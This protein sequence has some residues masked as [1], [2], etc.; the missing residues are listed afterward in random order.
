MPEHIGNYQELQIRAAWYYYKAE[1]TQEEIAHRLGINRARVIKIL[2]QCRREGIVSFH[3]N[4]RFANCLELEKQLIDRYQLRAALIVPEIDPPMINKNLGAAGAQYIELNLGKEETLLGFGWGNT[5]SLTLKH[6][7]LWGH[8]EVSM[9]TL[10]GGI[11]AYLQNTYREETNPLFKFNSRFHIIPSPLL[12][13]SADTCRSIL[14]EP[15]VANIMQ[16]A[17]LANIA[18]VGIGPMSSNATFTQFGYI[19]PQELEILQ[20][21][22]GVGDILGQFFDKDGQRLQVDF[23]NRLISVS[24]ED[25]KNMQHVVGIAGGEHKA[26]AIQG[27]LQGRYLHSL[28]TDEN[29]ALKLLQ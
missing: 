3:I 11:T 20:K 6:L 12:V 10:S 24:L 21:Q 2:D 7:S 17:K 23:H 8:K 27:A 1:M 14:S 26:E 19:T 16:M 25:L 15:E 9:V 22:G 4:G 5:I 29:T 13:S 28:I 18:V